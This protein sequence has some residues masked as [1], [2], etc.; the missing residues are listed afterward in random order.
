MW[1]AAF[2]WLHE[3]LAD[4]FSVSQQMNELIC[5]FSSRFKWITGFGISKVRYSFLEHPEWNYGV[6]TANKLR[7][8]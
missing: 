5:C 3:V 6:R 4:W 7:N 8:G 1:V 2:N